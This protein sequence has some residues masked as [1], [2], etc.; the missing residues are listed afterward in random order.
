V[1]GLASGIAAVATGDDHSCALTTAGGV[2]C[3]GFNNHG[4]LGNGTNL[5]S[6]TPVTVTGLSSGVGAIVAGGYHTCA[7]TTAGNLLCWGHNAS[8]Q[9]GDNSTTNR[10][11]PVPV[12]NLGSEVAAVAGGYSHTCELTTAGVVRCWGDNTYGQLGDGTTTERHAPVLV[13]SLAGV[14]T[15]VAGANG[16]TCAL[17][18]AGGALCWG[19]NGAGQLG[20]GSRT[21]SSL[22]VDVIVGDTYLRGNA[23]SGGTGMSLSIGESGGKV[24]LTHNTI[25][26][27]SGSGLA[28]GG[29]ARGDN[30]VIRNNNFV[31]NATYDLQ[32][33]QGAVGTQNFTMDASGNYW[34]VPA[35]QVANRI[36]DCTFDGNGCN[37]PSSTMAKVVFSPPLSAPDQ[38]APAFV[39]GLAVSPDP[40][41]LETATFTIDFSRPMSTATMPVLGFHDSR[42]GISET[43]APFTEQPCGAAL[44]VRGRFWTTYGQVCGQAPHSSVY[45]YDDRSWHEATP[46]DYVAWFDYMGT[47]YG[48]DNGDIWFLGGT[49]PRLARLHGAQWTAWDDPGQP[50]LPNSYLLGEDLSGRIWFWDGA[51]DGLFAFDGVVTW[52]PIALPSKGRLK[53][54]TIARDGQGQL[55]F[56]I[57][58]GPGSTWKGGLGVYDGQTWS[59]QDSASGLIYP[60]EDLAAVHDDSSGRIWVTLAAPQPRAHY[61]AMYDGVWH[62]YG[63]AQ[64]G[65]ALAGQIVRIVEIF[66]GSVWMLHES[67]RTAVY[68][69]GEWSTLD[70]TL[71]TQFIAIDPH[72]NVWM[73]PSVLWW[74]RDYTAADGQW[75]S[76]TRYQ[77]TFEFT[78]VVPRGTYS[79]TVGGAM[80]TDG[81]PAA[82]LTID[83]DVA[84]GGGVSS[85]PPLPPQV[86]VAGTGSLTALTLAWPAQSG[87]DGYRYA[88]GT[89]AGGRDVLGWTYLAAT[90][91]T[92]AGL[93]L[94]DGKTY[95]VT[96]QARGTNGLWSNNAFSASFVAGQAESGSRSLYMPNLSR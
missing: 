22:P 2:V 25:G 86:T 81:L 58:P 63:I 32:L 18:T 23:V 69:D 33:E 12:A 64:S 94:V 65:G 20:D 38:T 82:G 8:G 74:G 93:K 42:R 73:P 37:T 57:A 75:L 90:S 31:A 45:V 96:V 60:Y 59:Y 70:R 19:A 4:Q 1:A 21:A 88:L 7:V 80:G 77:T 52:T 40:V 30:L 62:Y 89:V 46:T 10:A 71:P 51:Y 35:N 48:A 16:H 72:L 17:T 5:D 78:P 79:L 3:W 91:V 55:W 29:L 13:S 83:F 6:T 95:F 34:N 68:R 27:N 11:I 41:G 85:V 56:R 49:G 84:Y 28:L 92:R 76:A 54:D 44:D 36:R 39:T 87:V 50:N 9:L 43:N 66:D 15:A 47:V 61:L 67:G 53:P 24:Y 26:Q 14:S